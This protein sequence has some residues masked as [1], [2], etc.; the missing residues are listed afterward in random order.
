MYYFDDVVEEQGNGE[1]YLA[2]INTNTTEKY[3]L[4]K[5]RI[6]TTTNEMKLYIISEADTFRYNRKLKSKVEMDDLV[7]KISQMAEDVDFKN[8]SIHSPYRK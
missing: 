1:F 6:S 5:F 8:N 2:L 4:D 7:N 3:V